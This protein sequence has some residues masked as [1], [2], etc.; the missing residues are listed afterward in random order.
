MD[1][2]KDYYQILGVSPSASLTDIRQAYRMLAR[3]WHPDMH[4]GESQYKIAFAEEWF[5]HINEAYEVL[6]DLSK[7]ADYDDVYT[8]RHR[9]HPET[10]TQ[11][12]T[13]RQ[14]SPQ[15]TWSYSRAKTNAYVHAWQAREYA[16][17]QMCS[18][19]T[20]VKRTG[21]G[22]VNTIILSVAA[23]CIVLYGIICWLSG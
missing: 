20:M 12:Q 17:S 23:I 8:T 1:Y 15:N 22:D 18:Q 2:S 7:K 3:Q 10:N 16:K 11:E 19:Q 5:K 21:N 9:S 4:A 6:S 14:T 13:K